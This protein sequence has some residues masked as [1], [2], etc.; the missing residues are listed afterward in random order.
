MKI[1]YNWLKAYI[2]LDMPVEELAELLTNTGL[3]VE[4]VENIEA[5]RGGLEGVVIGEVCTCTE[6][7]NA[8]SLK[9][10]T[11]NV[12]NEEPLQIVCGAPNVAAGQKVVVAVVGTTLYPDPEKDGLKIKKA[13]IRGESSAGMICAEDELGLG[14]NHNGI[15]VLPDDA[16]V[17]KPAG[18]HFEL[19]NDVVFE[20][21]LTPN[22]T[23]AMSHV[24]VARDI[25][26]ALSLREIY[27]YTPPSVA[28]FKPDH[29]NRPFQVTV[30]DSRACTRY[31]GLSISGVK[32]APSPDGLQKKLKAIGL[33]PVNNVVDITNFVLHELGQ[34]LHAF[35]GD[36][37]AHDQIW[38]KK[39]PQDTPF[40]TLDG[41][42]RKLD[43]EDLMICDANGG[44]CIAGIFGG[45]GCGVSNETTTV[46]LESAR[47]D[48]VTVRKSAARHSLHTDAGFRFE[49]GVDPN[50]TLTALKRAAML[51]KEIAGGEI[52]SEISDYNPH[53]AKDFE[54]EFNTDRCAMLLGHT[55]PTSV[56]RNILTALEIRIEAEKGANWKLNV[57]PY[58]VD[59]QREADVI[60]EVLRIYGFNRIGLPEKTS[61]SLVNSTGKDS[62]EMQNRVAE[63]LIARG[64]CE[65]IT[66]SLTASGYASIANAK[67]IKEEAQVRIL[68]PLSKEMNTMRQTMLFGGLEAIR[69][70]INRQHPDLQLF[71]FGRTY[72]KF[73]DGYSEQDHLAI[74]L[75]GARETES[76]FAKKGST[77]FHQLKGAVQTVLQKLGIFK[78]PQTGAVRSELFAD[79]MAYKIG[80]K[81]VAELGWVKASILHKMEM[82]QEVLYADLAWNTIMELL[83]MNKVRYKEISKFPTMRRDISMMLSEETTFEEVENTARKCGKKLLKEIGLFDIYRGPNLEKG[84]KSYAVSFTF[85][86]QQKTM[87]DSQIDAVI[88]RIQTELEQKLGAAIR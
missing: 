1:S 88:Q 30:E 68:D 61:I 18:E 31:A 24:G 17:G 27:P 8:R 32:V 21:G 37:I 52:S 56:L 80:G 57:P 7:P 10:T 44:L 4:G 39:L 86:N 38:V 87:T 26:A 22:R 23:D 19:E 13:R 2:N 42:K 5:V 14:T 6:H 51:I 43:A 76:W 84:K 41:E 49:R 3:E 83:H 36:K 69:H 58:R 75:T 63:T 73:P 33:A 60:E 15:M 62:R 65:I 85:E 20:I 81:K 82:D 9:I 53:P 79:G 34:P 67:H 35:D 54:V 45:E 77:S 46:F 25:A 55:L 50:G 70:N 78:G 28:A 48:P 40:V 29:N 71:E 59:V 11:V 16:V 47:F 66:N 74:F 12:G 72:N 64:F